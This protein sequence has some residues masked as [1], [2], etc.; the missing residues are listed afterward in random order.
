MVGFCDIGEVLPEM[1]N[2]FIE[3][4]QT[5]QCAS[6][7]TG[8]QAILGEE[9]MTTDSPYTGLMQKV[10]DE[11]SGKGHMLSEW[12]PWG[13]HGGYISICSRCNGKLTILVDTKTNLVGSDPLMSLDFCPA[14][15]PELMERVSREWSD[16]LARVY[17]LIL[18][19][20][21]PGEGKSD[22]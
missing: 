7:S 14:D 3:L 15:N 9:T 2:Q 18:S 8:E 13:I 5:V 22:V 21:A 4:A 10:W 20:P 17:A 11:A 6:Y 16:V 1:G 12:E 19:W